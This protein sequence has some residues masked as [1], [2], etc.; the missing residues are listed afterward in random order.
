[1]SFLHP[2]ALL[3]LVAAAVP[4]LLHLVQRRE[5][6]TVVFPAV[7]Y[8]VQATREHQRRL[9]VRNWLLLAVRTLL[10]TA[11]VLAAAGPLVPRAGLAEHAPAA[12]VLVLD[13][14]LSSAVVVGGTPR[15]DE[16]RR[17]ADA[18]LARA[19]PGDALWLVAADGVPR[20]GDA[21]ALRALAQGLAT[22]VRRLDLGAAIGTAAALLAGEPRPGEIVLLTDAQR[23]ALGAAGTDVPLLVA[24]PA[25]TPPANAGLAALDVGPQPWSVEGG[26]VA[27]A[28][29]GDSGLQVPVT[30]RAGER[31]T[32]QAVATVG[33]PAV[34]TLPALPA[35]WQL[36]EGELAGDELR[37]DDRRVAAVRVAPV[38]RAECA[39]AG[40]YAVAACE[41]LESNA[42]LA[43]GDEVRLGGFGT[44][45][46]VILP[47]AD[48]AALGALNRELARRGVPWRF[49][50]PAPAATSDSGALLAPVRVARRLRLEPVG[51]G[52]T[53]VVA[54]V[55][56]EP[57]IV[58]AGGTLL[59][60]SRLEPEW[61]DLPL[62]AGFVRVVDQLL[63]RLARGE[64][65][66]L[67][68]APGDPVHLPD[69][70]D[71]VVRGAEVRPVE[72][73]AAYAPADTGV[74]FLRSG[75]DTVGVL[76]VNP[77]PRESLLAPASDAEVRALWPGARVVPLAEAPALAFSQGAR[78]DLTGPLLW[79]ALVLGL[80]EVAL[81]SWW[82]KS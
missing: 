15:L 55:R 74:H 34:L 35:G 80:V 16:L 20:R 45:A 28:L 36:L 71:A 3:G 17:T 57:W 51:S 66:A 30:L 60:G 39:E 73:G 44:R 33:A 14:S 64:L 77:D 38:A 5:P 52:R 69:V 67:D 13:N 63:N 2:W 18:V 22:D 47:P 70:V 9:R 76:V 31:A 41:V 49:G 53:G 40:R 56:G 10:V 26:R 48:P 59:V 54:T 21:T 82:R 1:M 23:T 50:A 24:R 27:A 8:L 12:L 75:A 6:P 43:R 65:A 25:T 11:L 68:A 4:L 61:T 37:L 29:A 62:D 7:R 78:G 81:A 79:L 32:R 42:R 72:G 58:R 19:T 46:G